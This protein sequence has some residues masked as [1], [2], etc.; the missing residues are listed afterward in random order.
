VNIA[1]PKFLTSPYT[2]PILLFYTDYEV[3]SYLCQTWTKFVNLQCLLSWHMIRFLICY[4]HF[5]VGPSSCSINS[6]ERAQT[7]SASPQQNSE[8]DFRKRSKSRQ[9]NCQVTPVSFKF[10]S[11]SDSQLIQWEAQCRGFGCLSS[12]A[13]DQTL[14][15]TIHASL[16]K[17]NHFKYHFVTF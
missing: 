5:T 14:N 10:S 13:T 1:C 12:F 17:Y 8:T 9:D 7:T 3:T 4:V 11:K 16:P 15:S 2:I 6:S